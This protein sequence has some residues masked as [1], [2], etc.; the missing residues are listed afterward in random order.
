MNE[1]PKDGIILWLSLPL[2]ALVIMASIT[3]LTTPDFYAAETP[4]WQAQSTGQDMVDLFIISPALLITCVLAYQKRKGGILAWAGV[5]IYLLYT[6]IIFCFAVH[7]NKLFI[8]Y[9]LAL[10]LSFYA[11]LWFLQMHKTGVAKNFTNVPRRVTGIYFIIIAIIFYFPWLSE[12]FP[13]VMKN[14][15][16]ESIK[17]TGLLT[18]AVHVIDLSVF[19]PGVFITG[20][21]LLKKKLAGYLMAPVLLSFFILM[22]ITI[23]VLILVMKQKGLDG[24]SVLIA[25]MGALAITSA[26]LLMWYIKKMNESNYL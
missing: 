20:V 11:L 1:T 7:F 26:G 6:F 5:V 10:G 25:M 12:I 14:K 2:A 23:S 16:P 9:C 15:T 22:D 4:N 3:G 24:N 19:L 18:N 17:E 13:A 21:L 8:V